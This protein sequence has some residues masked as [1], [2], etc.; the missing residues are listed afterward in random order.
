MSKKGESTSFFDRGI[1][2]LT[3]KDGVED[4][5]VIEDI[6]EEGINT[7]LEVRFKRDEIYT[8]TGT[9]LVAV[10]PFKYIPGIYEQDIVRN[11]TGVRMGAIA[12]HVF[13]TAEA[14]Y[15]N[16]RSTPGNQSV[17]I[18]GESGAGKTENTKLILQYLTAVTSNPKWIEQQI[19][20]ANTILEAFGNA[21][22]VRNN[23]SSRFGKFTK[24]CF[25]NEHAIKGCII[26]DYLLEQ[27]RVVSQSPDE[28][29]YHV[30]YQLCAG[31][32]ASPELAGKFQVKEPKYY[33]Y[34]NQS[35]CI[36]IPGLDDKKEFDAL[37]LA[38]TVLSIQTE[39][40]DSLFCIL[41]TVLLLG[42]LEFKDV[43]GESI[44]F[45]PEDVG[46]IETMCKLLKTQP[47]QMKKALAFR[48]LTV[49][50][51]T[52]EIP[53][54]IGE[55]REN[56]NAM[57]KA[58][59]SRVF[60]VIIHH[61]NNC[62]NPGSEP[63]RFIGVL[64][65]FG[66]ENFKINSFEQLCI[67]YTNEK[68]HKFFNDYCFQV[69]QAEYDAEGINYSHISFH[70]NQDALDAIDKPPNCI[71]KFLDEECR[72]PK[73]TD[74]TY[75]EKQHKAL[76]G[77]K[78]Y[79]KPTD[80]RTVN[81]LFGVTHFAGPVMYTIV[82]FLDKNKDAQQDLLFDMMKSSGDAFVKEVQ[83]FRDIAAGAGA[84]AAAAASKDSKGK[85]KPTIGSI[86]KEQ[87]NSL[88]AVLSQT[89]PF[90][91]R[92]IKPNSDKVAAK[93]DKQMVMDQLR[94]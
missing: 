81:E 32:K 1:E 88:V 53:L 31:C 83:K 93:F 11:Y 22:T 37:R 3:A 7:N 36:A 13:A 21:K 18:S 92:C 69:E 28:R 33:N 71:L 27:S 40:Q 2:K 52:T 57:A 58:L 64:D 45:T 42:N 19:M 34:L 29:N 5:T 25:N 65:I 62:T 78:N 47:A 77:V 35:G 68:L 94:Y 17:I 16:I 14:T 26:Q 8:F 46:L 49:R 56:R 79:I 82:G 9:I 75:L 48:Q 4:M 30:F 54:K 43:D 66:F 74:K 72:F 86:F 12:P 50:D 55:A 60:T 20:E 80:K 39:T 24:V 61:I 41:S 89:T 44:D 6:D 51:N 87:L 10:N 67:N 15:E 70:D 76:E 23:N 90:Y 59:Y 38:M 63:A 85:G 91:V 73:G 84:E